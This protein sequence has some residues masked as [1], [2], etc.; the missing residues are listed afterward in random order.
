[1]ED[2]AGTGFSQGSNRCIFVAIFG[3][4][5]DILK[6]GLIQRIGNGQSTR[7]WQDNWIPRSERLTPVSAISE[8][9]PKLVAELIDTMSGWWDR[10]ELARH[11]LPMDIEAICNIP[12]SSVQQDDFWAWH[13]EKTG[14]FSV[15]SAY[16]MFVTTKKA[17][18]D[19]L[20]GR[21]STSSN[22][23]ERA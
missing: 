20:E 17:H 12:I 7:V 3:R 11:F 21:P 10:G 23:S 16:R 18:E 5:R 9:P 14:I 2:F 1:M 22:Q 19:W 15:R 4:G 8:A 13:H 6:L